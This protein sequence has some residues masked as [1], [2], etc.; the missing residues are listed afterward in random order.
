MPVYNPGVMDATLWWSLL[1]VCDRNLSDPAAYVVNASKFN[2]SVI[3]ESQGFRWELSKTC[4]H[5]WQ[6]EISIE[7]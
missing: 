2:R 3:R 4:Y 6:N 1:N 7:D 5:A